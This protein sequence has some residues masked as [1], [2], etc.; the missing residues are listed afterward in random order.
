MF[1]ENKKFHISA[2]SFKG[3]ALQPLLLRSH[4]TKYMKGKLETDVFL[5]T[6]IELPGA[7]LSEN[8]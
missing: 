4:T 2:F 8:D 7:A 6:N 5:R 3:L 1:V